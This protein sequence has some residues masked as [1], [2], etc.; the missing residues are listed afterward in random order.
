M[1]P[2]EYLYGR[3]PHVL[4]S[5]ELDQ[6]IASQDPRVVKARQ[7]V[8]IQCVGSREPERPYCSRVCC[9][10]S[11]ES[12]L[13]LKDLNPE[14]EVF[15]LYREVR[16][17]GDKELLYQE[18]REKGVVFIRYDLESKPRVARTAAG[19]L[20]VNVRDP[21]LGRPLVLAPDLLTLAG[22]ILPSPTAEL[23]ELFKVPRNTEGFFN[24]AH[25]KLRPV[26]CVAEGI[27]LAGMAH[28]PKPI[29]ESIAQARPRRPGRPRCWPWRRWPWN[30]W[31][32]GWIRTF[33]W[34]AASAKSLRLE[35][36]VLP[37]C[38]QKDFGPRTS[39]LTA[40]G[41]AYAPRAARSGP[42]TCCTLRTG[43]SWPP[44]TPAG[45]A[46]AVE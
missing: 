22:A 4:L 26:D 32:P 20:E 41:A 34:A 3:H 11:V 31:C 17:Y 27:Y 37:G 1:P 7:A 28:Y 45:E 46:E 12:A 38:R 29:D 5:L 33:A 21:I 44:S 24:E 6:A 15:I 9:T 10:H 8:F 13:V 2:P 16:T 30:R 23:A 43:R 40:R 18:A 39:P 42:S 19:G 35:P 14:V 25:A 36:C